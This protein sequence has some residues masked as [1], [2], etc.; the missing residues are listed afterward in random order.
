MKITEITELLNK[1]F[2]ITFTSNMSS[3]SLL[4]FG[5]MVRVTGIPN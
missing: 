2:K 4:Y 1:N 5:N 3:D